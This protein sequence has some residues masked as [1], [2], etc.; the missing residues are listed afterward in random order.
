MEWVKDKIF[1]TLIIAVV[2]SYI[3][4]FVDFQILKASVSNDRAI[5][6]EIKADVKDIKRHL[7]GI[8]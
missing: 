8:E 3:G 7:M 4:F 2:L 6:K 1:P 5:I